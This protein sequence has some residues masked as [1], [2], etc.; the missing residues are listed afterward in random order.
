MRDPLFSFPNP[1]G[2]GGSG[3]GG[4][5]GGA[6]RDAEIQEVVAVRRG[7]Q[8]HSGAGAFVVG[9]RGGAGR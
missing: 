7:G 1:S 2:V 6:R 8:G 5:L 4:C 3:G 9:L